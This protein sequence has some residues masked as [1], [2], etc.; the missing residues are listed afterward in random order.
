M[1]MRRLA[2]FLLVCGSGILLSAS[3][4]KPEYVVICHVGV[5]F[6][7]IPLTPYI[8]YR[9]NSRTLLVERAKISMHMSH[10]DYFGECK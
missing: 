2:K 10:G 7:A 1:N 9:G 6:G 4:Y 8:P 3:L 5:D